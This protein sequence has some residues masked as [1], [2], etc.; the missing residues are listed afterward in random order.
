MKRM[1]FYFY[2]PLIAWYVFMLIIFP[3]DQATIARRGLSPIEAR[4]F[5]LSV[6]VPLI[7]IWLIAHYGSWY[8]SEHG[9]S[10]KKYPD[11][12]PLMKLGTAMQLLA[13]YL[14]I[15]TVIK[16]TCN[17][18]AQLWPSILSVTNIAITYINLVIP[19]VAFILISQAAHDLGKLAKVR[20]SLRSIYILSL[21][22]IGL[23]VLYCYAVFTVTGSI[24]PTNW[25]ITTMEPIP[26]PIRIV[27]VIIPYLFMW[28][29]GLIS[30]F[31]I[32]LYQQQVE[33]LIYRQS[34]KL[35]SAG[36]AAVILTSIALQ[37]IIAVAPSIQNLPF[38]AIL[39]LAY[40][41]IMLL[42]AAFF[43]IALGV[44][45]LRKLEEV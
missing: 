20:A 34:L 6:A 43:T 38:G 31:K 11:G 35:L 2:L 42:G 44:G 14:P 27:T 40:G 23:G 39:T 12:L 24:P 18:L 26:L 17:Y 13:L 25:L 30:V 5:S 22:F 9:R 1:I 29:I 19:L 7:V 37:F 28:A 36:L 4:V 45:R 21:A 16:I 8:L 33:G 32:Y 15:R 41:C 10:I 3:V